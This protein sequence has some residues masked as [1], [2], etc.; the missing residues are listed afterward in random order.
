MRA[1]LGRPILKNVRLHLQ[2]Q[3][4]ITAGRLSFLLRQGMLTS[5]IEGLVQIAVEEEIIV[6]EFSR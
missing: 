3:H 6:M 1:S 5:K 4:V 2:S